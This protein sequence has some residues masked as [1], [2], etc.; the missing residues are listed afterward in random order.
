M[1]AAPPLKKANVTL[2]GAPAPAL[3]RPNGVATAP[4]WSATVSVRFFGMAAVVPGAA[5][6]APAVL[7][8]VL[9]AGGAARGGVVW[10]WRG[11]V[12][13]AED[14]ELLPEPQAVATTTRTPTAASTP[15]AR[16]GKGLVRD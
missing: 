4:D 2:Y 13:A 7:V 16:Q 1:A 5:D 6:D 14:D 9:A 8:L 12:V 15:R 11:A 3:A 10:L